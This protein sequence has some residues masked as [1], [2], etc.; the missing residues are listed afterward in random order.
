MILY[1]KTIPY[2][3][4][5]ESVKFLCE[6]Y[7]R[8]ILREDSLKLLQVPF[9]VIQNHSSFYEHFA[10]SYVQ[11]FAVFSLSEGTSQSFSVKAL[12]CPQCLP[13]YLLIDDL[14]VLDYCQYP[15]VYSK[16]FYS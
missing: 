13:P 14:R 4:M 6:F 5:L 7:L 3:K 16:D 12:V 11:P 15:S 1:H 2:S 10:L 8:R 9:L